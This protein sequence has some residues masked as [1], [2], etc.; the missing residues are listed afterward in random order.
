MRSISSFV[1]LVAD[2]SGG[3]LNKAEERKDRRTL[4]S[5]AFGI[6][7]RLPAYHANLGYCFT[8]KGT[9][10]ASSALCREWSGT[11]LLVASDFL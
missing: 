2:L 6:Q 3:F 7:R 4:A 8:A 10:V 5:L 11:A 1:R 9:L